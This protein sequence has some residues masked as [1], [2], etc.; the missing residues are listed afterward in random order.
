M[1]L[2]RAV[3]KTLHRAGVPIRYMDGGTYS[4]P[5]IGHSCLV[6]DLIFLET[7]GIPLNNGVLRPAGYGPWGGKEGGRALKN[8]TRMLQFSFNYFPLRFPGRK[9]LR[10]EYPADRP[11]GGKEC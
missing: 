8:V 2:G 4:L 9:F 5:A 11:Y 7:D 10:A 1:G 3:L 6:S